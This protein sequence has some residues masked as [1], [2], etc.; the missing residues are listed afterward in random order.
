MPLPP[1]CGTHSYHTIWAA[2]AELL[3]ALESGTRTLFASSVCCCLCPTVQKRSL[4]PPNAFHCTVQCQW[5]KPIQR[6]VEQWQEGEEGYCLSLSLCSG[7]SGYQSSLPLRGFWFLVCGFCVL[8]LFRRVDGI[9]CSGNASFILPPS[10]SLSLPCSSTGFGIF[11]VFLVG[12]HS[13]W[14]PYEY[15]RAFDCFENMLSPLLC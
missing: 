4:G 8:F 15:R 7:S 1:L 10:L 12:L 11:L 14:F 2:H 5:A 13:T 9:I 6:D 3:T